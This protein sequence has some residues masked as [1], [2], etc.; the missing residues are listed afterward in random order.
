[1]SKNPRTYTMPV[2]VKPKMAVGSVV[3]VLALLAISVLI[4]GWAAMIALGIVG[5]A[6]S[7]WESLAVAALARFVML[8]VSVQR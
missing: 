6:T 3:G 7:Y 4:T 2:S 1:M 8:P 5:A